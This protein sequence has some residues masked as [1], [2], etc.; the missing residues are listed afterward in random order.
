MRSVAD[1]RKTDS[2]FAHHRADIDVRLRR[3]LSGS[4]FASPCPRP[5][6]RVQLMPRGSQL[7]RG[8]LRLTAS[9]QIPGLDSHKLLSRQIEKRPGNCET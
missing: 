1:S 7:S 2:P 3:S 9:R 8:A 5:T 6:S 4:I